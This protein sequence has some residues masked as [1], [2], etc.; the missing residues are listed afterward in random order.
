MALSQPSPKLVLALSR[1]SWLLVIA[2]FAVVF[3]RPAIFF[4]AID[5][6]S[7][8]QNLGGLATDTW[9]WREWPMWLLPAA[10]LVAPTLLHRFQLAR[11]SPAYQVGRSSEPGGGYR[12]EPPLVWGLRPASVRRRGAIYGLRLALAVV[13]CIIPMLRLMACRFVENRG[14]IVYDVR[15]VPE[16]TF[17]AALVLI[18][19]LFH[20]PTPGRLLDR[21]G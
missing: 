9:T 21:Q 6:L 10:A 5:E 12:A 4:R 19:L 2:C 13:L 18:A 17:E 14:C 16:Y 20:A 3:A 1:L 7:A 15:S 8:G 11:C